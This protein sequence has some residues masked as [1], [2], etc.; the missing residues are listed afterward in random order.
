MSSLMP[1]PRVHQVTVARLAKTTTT[2]SE[3]PPPLR[4]PGHT[5]DVVPDAVAVGAPGDSSTLSE[6]HDRAERT[7]APFR[8]PGHT[9]DVVPDAVA[10]GAPGDSSTLSENH[11]HAERTSAAV[12]K[13]RAHSRCRP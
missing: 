5:H 13:S 7:S 8:N 2:Q 10:A 1:S 9:H 4:N 11:D 6:N 3:H 12:E